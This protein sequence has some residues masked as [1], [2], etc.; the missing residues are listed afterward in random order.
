MQ[1][2][3]KHSCFPIRRSVYYFIV[4]YMHGKHLF[5][6]VLPDDLEIAY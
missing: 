5:V 4:M 3:K 6:A 2:S 1:R